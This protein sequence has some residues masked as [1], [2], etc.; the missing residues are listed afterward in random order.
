MNLHYYPRNPSFKGCAA[1]TSQQGS[2]SVCMY[3]I[4]GILEKMNQE[5][6]IL[7]VRCVPVVGM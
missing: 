1:V 6:D 5:A 3:E 2:H 7:P 4:S